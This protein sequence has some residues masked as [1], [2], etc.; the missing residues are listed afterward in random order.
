MSL[1]KMVLILIL[2]VTY[3]YYLLRVH[4]RGLNRAIGTTL[5]LGAGLLVIFPDA[6]N[7]VARVFGVGRG[8]DLVFYILFGAFAFGLVVIYSE[9]RSLNR[10]VTLLARAVAI[11]HAE[12]RNPVDPATPPP[13]EAQTHG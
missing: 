3:I 8:V 9:L 11:Q 1:I 12:N 13:A 2:G 4:S 10:S 6:S 7:Q 5:F